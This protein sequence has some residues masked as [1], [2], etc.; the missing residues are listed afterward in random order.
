M[1]KW[2]LAGM[3]LWLLGA[4]GG[5][6]STGPLPPSTAVVLEAAAPDSLLSASQPLP[7]TALVQ[8]SSGIENVVMVLLTLRR[9]EE[10]SEADTL[11]LQETIA[12]DRAQFGAAFDSTFAAGKKGTYSLEFQAVDVE[13]RVS[14]I[15]VRQIYLQNE[16]P[17]MS[18]P[19]APDTLQREI[20]VPLQVHL[21]VTDPQGVA[22]LDSIYFKFQKPDGSFGGESRNEGGFPFW[23]FD[24][25]NAVVSGDREANDG[26]FSWRFAIDVDPSNNEPPDIGTYT[27]IFF[28]RD[29]VGHIVTMSKNFELIPLER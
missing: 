2:I 5:S 16:P 27:F 25:G 4:C 10:V 6:E 29:K 17:R 23:L 7:F 9:G 22:D 13:N 11:R 3:A 8:D 20:G 14:D 21:T 26:V 19:V 28:A 12:A 24:D 15:L 18:N 1:C